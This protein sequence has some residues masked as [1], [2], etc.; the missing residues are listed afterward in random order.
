MSGTHTHTH[1]VRERTQ[2]IIPLKRK[3]WNNIEVDGN[4][5]TQYASTYRHFDI[6]TQYIYVTT[7][8]KPN[9]KKAT[10]QK[11]SHNHFHTK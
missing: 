1:T 9:Q 10:R 5:R 7:E 4:R 3:F 8:I 6:Y 11:H 2:E